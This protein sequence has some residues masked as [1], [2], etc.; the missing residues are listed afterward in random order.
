MTREQAYQAMKDGN[1]ISHNYFGSDEFY[2]LGK[3]GEVIAEDGVN[4]TATFWS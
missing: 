3:H 1:K 4:H 2:A